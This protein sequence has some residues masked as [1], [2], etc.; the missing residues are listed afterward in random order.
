MLRNIFFIDILDIN[1]YMSVDMYEDANKVIYNIQDKLKLIDLD[2]ENIP[3]SLKEDVGLNYR[4]SKEFDDSTYKVYKYISVK[5]VQI[6]ISPVQR[7]ASIKERYSKAMPIY[8]YFENK[9]N[10]LAELMDALANTEVEDIEKLEK[11]QEIF[12]NKKPDNIKYKDSF[13]WQIYYSKNDDK[14]FMLVPIVENDNAALFYILKEKI[15]CEKTGKDKK[16][17]VPICQEDYS[18][19]II[20][21]SRITEIENYLWFFTKKWPSI[22]EVTEENGDKSIHIIGRT[23]IYEKIEST[24]KI[25][26]KT[27]EEADEKYKL[28][29]ALF[30]IASDLKYLYNFD[31]NINDKGELIFLYNED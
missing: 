20:S 6:L 18:D 17:Y 30:I 7:L 24:Y 23:N 3:E 10:R 14:Y 22:Y 5:D 16:I 29:K 19:A 27:Q 21:K 9:E 31:T 12:S 26:L 1:Y 28:I 2:V 4:V 15:K 13:K 8:K 25:V 11:E